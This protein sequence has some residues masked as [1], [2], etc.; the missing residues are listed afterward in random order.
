MK[1]VY[2]ENAPFPSKEEQIGIVAQDL[3]KIA[4]Y[5]VTK[6][7]NGTITDLREVNSQ[8][9]VFLLINAIKEQQAQIEKMQKEIDTLK[10]EKH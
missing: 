10:K 3:E 7:N 5:M 8:A 6:T 9:Y 1:F 4:P 2:K